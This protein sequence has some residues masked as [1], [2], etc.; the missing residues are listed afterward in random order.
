MEFFRIVVPDLENICREYIR[1]IEQEPESLKREWIYIP[2][3]TTIEYN[4][5]DE[6]LS[7]L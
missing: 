3:N 5:R 4:L 7:L 2:A 1:I 6:R